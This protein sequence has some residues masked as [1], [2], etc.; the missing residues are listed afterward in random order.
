MQSIVEITVG[1]QWE[2]KCKALTSTQNSQVFC[3]WRSSGKLNDF[4]ALNFQL[5]LPQTELSPM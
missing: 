1:K 2:I 4:N 5:I 3:K